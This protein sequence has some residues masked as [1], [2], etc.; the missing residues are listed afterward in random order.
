MLPIVLANV[1]VCGS[2]PYI[3]LTFCHT[4]VYIYIHTHIQEVSTLG[5]VHAA[6]RIGDWKL[7]LNEWDVG[8]YEEEDIN[9]H[10]FL[11]K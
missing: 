7:L 3:L 2:L 6:I 5:Q 1:Y 11:D 8:T 10:L 9:D 4:V